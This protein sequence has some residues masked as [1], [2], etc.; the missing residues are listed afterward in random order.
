M[1]GIPNIA[2][3]IRINRDLELTNYNNGYLH[4]STVSTKKSLELIKSQKKRCESVN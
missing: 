1:S 2:E 3:E 4:I